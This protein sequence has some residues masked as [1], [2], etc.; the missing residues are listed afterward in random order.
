MNPNARTWSNLSGFKRDAIIAVLRRGGRPDADEPDRP[1]GLGIKRELEIMRDADVNHSRLYPNLSDLAD[2]GLVD[3]GE[4]DKRT[5]TYRVTDAGTEALARYLTEYVG[6][7]TE[8]HSVG[9]LPGMAYDDQT[10]RERGPE[11]DTEA[12]GSTSEDGEDHADDPS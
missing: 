6:R 9:M 7:V 12:G 11:D 10:S 1:Y 8:A 5:N 2:A 3:V 4:R